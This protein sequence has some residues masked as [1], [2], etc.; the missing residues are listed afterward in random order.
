MIA[1]RGARAF[2]PE[3]TIEAFD[4]AARLGAD[5]V[6]LDVQLTADGQLVVVH[7]DTLERCSNVREVFP[8][9]GN[10]PVQSF[11]LAEIQGLDAGSWF[12]RE[13]R[14][15]SLT[16]Q[17]FLQS[18]TPGESERFISREDRTHYASGNV[19]HPTLRQALVRIH[20]LGLRVNAELKAHSE[21][22]VDRSVTEQTVRLVEELGL[23]EEVLISSF[24][25]ASLRR[26]KELLPAI[27]TGVLVVETQDDPVRYCRELAASAFHPPVGSA[28][29][30][31][32]FESEEF[33]ATGKL[34]AELFR[35]LRAAGFDVNVWTENDPACMK[36]FIEAGVTGI[37]TDY[38]NRLVELLD[39]R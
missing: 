33:R 14:E 10:H 7:D 19:R 39:H 5:M 31:V 22:G 18:L 27:A 13:L 17:P 26:V 1:H 35:S 8:D 20:E 37:F 30:P 38:P 6:E 2:A 34:P 36:C 25:H 11:A 16:R 4:K 28:T 32:L 23:C 12:V 24:D 21:T 3:N 9:R 29:N 15:P